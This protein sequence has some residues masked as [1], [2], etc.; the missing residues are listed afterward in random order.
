MNSICQRGT[1]LCFA[2]LCT[3]MVRNDLKNCRSEDQGHG[4]KTSSGD[5]ILSRKPRV[6]C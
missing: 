3:L 2:E 4:I 6:S 5:W 1:A